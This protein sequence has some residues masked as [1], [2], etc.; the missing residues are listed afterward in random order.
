MC[1]RIR[2]TKS[3]RATSA[4]PRLEGQATP[5][6]CAHPHVNALPP[7]CATRETAR[8]STPHSQ[9]LDICVSLVRNLVAEAAGL[10]HQ[11]V[12]RQPGAWCGRCV[13][14]VRSASLTSRPLR[15]PAQ[16]TQAEASTMK[17]MLLL[18]LLLLVQLLLLLLPL[19]VLP[20]L[21]LLLLLL[22]P[23]WPLSACRPR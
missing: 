14:V 18:L 20:V 5:L 8:H 23:R 22:P 6:P 9:R 21:L 10:M 13:L 2:D 17:A 4:S 7:R 16:A 11:P 1:V 19:L 12:R 15:A 3:T